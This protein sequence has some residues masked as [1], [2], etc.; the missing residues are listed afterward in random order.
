VQETFREEDDTIDNTV[1]ILEELA[2]GKCMCFFVTLFLMMAA[3][4]ISTSLQ[5]M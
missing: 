3:V 1:I 5:M 4:C 2:A